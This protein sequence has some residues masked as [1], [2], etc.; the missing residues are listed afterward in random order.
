LEHLGR[1]I[2][3]RQTISGGPGLP[4]RAY[5]RIFQNEHRAIVDAIRGGAVAQARAAMRRHLLN[6]RKRYERFA[7]KSGGV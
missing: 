7:A 5:S 2:I 4:R 1:L 6:S 3:P